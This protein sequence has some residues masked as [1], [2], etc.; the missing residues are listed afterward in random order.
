MSKGAIRG[1]PPRPSAQIF[2]RG[3]VS[4]RTQ[5]SSARV[6]NR[7]HSRPRASAVCASN[8]E[9]AVAM[10]YR[11][12]IRRQGSVS[13]V[14]NDVLEFADIA[15]PIVCFEEVERVFIN[16]F[17]HLACLMCISMEEIFEQHRNILSAF[18]KR[19]DMD[20]KYVQTI[21]EI[22]A[23]CSICLRHV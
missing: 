16:A 4:E 19:R 17:E 11:H 7:H 9:S 1:S 3:S 21:E 15:R 8:K 10:S 14:F 22:R 18:S 6:Q 12:K 13:P 23:E 20:R 5:S 2:A